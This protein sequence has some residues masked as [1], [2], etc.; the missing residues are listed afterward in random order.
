MKPDKN[1]AELARELAFEMADLRFKLRR[2]LQVK[3]KENNW[4]ISF[5]VLEILGVLYRKDGMNQQEIADELV[6]DKSSIT[7]LIDNAE[8]KELV[9]RT[10]DQNDRRN[11][12]IFL[13]EKGRSLILKLNPWAV[14]IY[15]KATQH[16]AYEEVHQA[17]TVARKMNEN[18]KK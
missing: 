14:D 7:Y 17:L 13:T 9:E 2:V 18:L 16:L 10:E 5:E 4:E 6:K 8:K 11:K 12:L 15:E 3:I 1:I